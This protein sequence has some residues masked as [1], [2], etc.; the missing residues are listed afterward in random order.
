MNEKRPYELPELF[1]IEFY[2]DVITD[3]IVDNDGD[4]RDWD[5]SGKPW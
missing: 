5:S 1:V 3:S 4:Y 2:Q